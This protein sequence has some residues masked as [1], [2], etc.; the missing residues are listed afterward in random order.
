MRSRVVQFAWK[1]PVELTAAPTFLEK[2]RL[3]P[4][5]AFVIGVD[6]A[7]RLVAPRYYGHDEDRMHGALETMGRA[8][9]EFLVAARTGSD[10]LRT[11]RDVALPGR[12][13]DLFREIPGFRVDVS[14]TELR[15]RTAKA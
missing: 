5:A 2:S 15:A 11:L 10:G 8:G 6:T 4:G 13:A 7:E 3:F 9:H 14:S 12:Y 1:A